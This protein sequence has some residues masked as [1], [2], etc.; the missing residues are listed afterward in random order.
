M[1][2]ICVDLDGV[3]NLYDGW[4]GPDDYPDPRPGAHE[5]LK[6]LKD[7][8][9]QVVIHTTRDEA[10]VRLWLFRFRMAHCVDQVT[11]IK[12]PAIAYID[13]R[14][15][16]FRGDF[17]STLRDLSKFRAHWENDK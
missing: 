7:Q 11:A 9:F 15:I 5:F 2:T 17:K 14:A 6:S 13:D 3:L 10:A 16:C 1:K 8:G 4:K 12:P